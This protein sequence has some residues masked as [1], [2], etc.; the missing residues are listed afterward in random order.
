MSFHFWP[1]ANIPL[2]FSAIVLLM[3]L[4]P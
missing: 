4:S 3:R 1:R 2:L